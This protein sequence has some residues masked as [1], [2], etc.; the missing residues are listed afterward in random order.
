MAKL[1]GPFGSFR[2]SGGAGAGLVYQQRWGFQLARVQRPP[3][4][5]R[6]AAQLAAR[7]LFAWLQRAALEWESDQSIL[8]SEI[9]AL[10]KSP[11]RAL[12]T[13]TNIRALRSQSTINNLVFVGQLQG[14]VAPPAIT[15]TPGSQSLTV[16]TTIPP[17]PTGY[18]LLYLEGWALKQQDPHGSFQGP[19]HM[20]SCNLPTISYTISGL[21]SGVQYVVGGLL[22]YSLSPRNGYDVAGPTVN[23]VGTPS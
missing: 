7:Q 2:A 17:A 9:S 15:L 5:P 20:G 4:Q 18:T 19:F 3:A 14:S 22:W 11:A 23:A 8:W 13:G 1:I 12:W 16:H 6:T 10:A 21:T